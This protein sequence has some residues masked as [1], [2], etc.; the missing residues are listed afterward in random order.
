M[1]WVFWQQAYQVLRLFTHPLDFIDVEVN[2]DR[3][4]AHTGIF[5]DRCTGKN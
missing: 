3:F 4:R 2:S 1:S 5:L